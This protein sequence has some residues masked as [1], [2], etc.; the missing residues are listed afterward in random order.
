MTTPVGELTMPPPTPD[1]PGP[2]GLVSP[3]NARK[4]RPMSESQESLSILILDDESLAREA[5][6]QC[7]AGQPHEVHMVATPRE[8][9]SLLDRDV[10]DVAFVDMRLEEGS[11]IDFIPRFLEAAPWLRIVLVT[12]HGSIESAVQA[13]RAGAVDYLS[14][15]FKPGEVRALTAKLL[16]AR[17]RERR[18]EAR[19]IR[20]DDHSGQPVLESSAPGMRKTLEMARQVAESEATILL[21][22]ESGTGKGVLAR[23]IHLWSARGK[24]PFSTV[25]CPSLSKELL[26]SELFG[27]VKGAFTGAVKTQPGRIETTEGGTLFLDEV[28]ELHPEIQPR[29]L[30]FL[31]DREYERVGDPRTRYADVRVV[32]A[33][34]QDLRQAI[35]K[36]TF[37]EDLYYRLNVIEIDV[38]PLRKHPEDILPLAHTF[39]YRFAKEYNRALHGFSPEAERRLRAYSWPGNIRELENAVERAVILCKSAEVGA[40]LLP[41]PL[42]EMEDA[43]MDHGSTEL[44]TLD[45]MEAN[46]IRH[47]L[48][49]TDSVEEAAQALGVSTTTLW[50]R[51]KKYEI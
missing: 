49:A 8:A 22:G 30:R 36:G 13:I 50:R 37:R 17:R 9:M 31:Q 51:R 21:T 12:A 18:L 44:V 1:L 32:T 4:N 33:T 28:A 11:G 46:Y 14:K 6:A 34:N 35:R 15:P 5:L 38:P 20:R 7:F 10:F 24:E 29:L 19:N 23:A 41:G 40:E 48:E 2:H 39:L 42:G 43:V 45:E 26:K 27:H 3:D 16:A 25:N 47:V